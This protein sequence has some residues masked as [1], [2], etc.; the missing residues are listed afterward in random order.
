M[1]SIITFTYCSKWNHPIYTSLVS[2]YYTYACLQFQ[3]TPHCD[4]QGTTQASHTWM[5]TIAATSESLYYRIPNLSLGIFPAITR[6]YLSFRTYSR[7]VS[8]QGVTDPFQVVKSAISSRSIDWCLQF[9]FHGLVHS[10]FLESIILFSGWKEDSFY[11]VSRCRATM[12]LSPHPNDIRVR[13]VDMS[14]PWQTPSPILT[15]VFLTELNL[16]LQM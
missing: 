7:R 13:L 1:S 8:R 2:I 5:R 12:E 11:P 4:S 9:D 15:D 6:S 14:V 10:I 16:S 3:Y